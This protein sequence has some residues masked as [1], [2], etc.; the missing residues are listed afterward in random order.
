MLH[1]TINIINKP[2][3]S[4]PKKLKVLRVIAFAILL[5]AT[6]AAYSFTTTSISKKYEQARQS[7]ESELWFVEVDAVFY[8]IV[9]VQKPYPKDVEDLSGEEVI[10]FACTQQE[11]E[12]RRERIE[13]IDSILFNV[14]ITFLFWGPPILLTIIWWVIEELKYWRTERKQRK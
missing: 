5:L 3:K 2:K 8:Y 10:D 1:G 12:E 14:A 11:A 6:Y 9:Q 7:C 13:F 4:L